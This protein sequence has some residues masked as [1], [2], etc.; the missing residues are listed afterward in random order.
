MAQMTHPMA[1]ALGV[2]MRRCGVRVSAGARLRRGAM[3]WE[4]P[5]L[6][7]DQGKGRTD[8]LVSLSAAALAAL[9]PCLA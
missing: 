5:S 4:Q 7:I 9:R 8:R 3:D 6:R 2:L 1:H